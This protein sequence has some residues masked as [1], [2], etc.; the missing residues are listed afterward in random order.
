MVTVTRS[1]KLR[2]SVAVLA[3]LLALGLM[4]WL[5]PWLGMTQSPFL[6]FFGAV[7]VSGWY[8]GMK[9]GVLATFLSAVLSN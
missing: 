2:Y 4:L 8:G 6:M 3:V 5:D 9:P 1:Q 7:M